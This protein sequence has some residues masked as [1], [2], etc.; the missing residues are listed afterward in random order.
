MKVE[1]VIFVA[2]SICF[3]SHAEAQVSQ[4]NVSIPVLAVRAD[5]AKGTMGV[6]R[7][8]YE[9][10]DSDRPL[11]ISVSD[12][13]P[14]GTG[15]S[16]R[17]A[18]WLAA[19]TA[20]VARNDPLTGVHLDFDLSGG[21]DGPSAGG[22]LCLAILSALDGRAIPNDFAMTGTIMA[23]GTIGAVGGIAEKLRA[24][25]RCGIKRVCIPTFARMDENFRDLLDLGKELKLEM[26]QVGTIAEAY[27]VLHRLP[28]RQVVRLN[29]AEV[30]RLSPNVENCLK[31]QF[32]NFARACPWDEAMQ[33]SQM[34]KSVEEFRAGLFGVAIMNL[35]SGLE[36]CV[37]AASK[38]ET[39][40]VERYPALEH[41]LPTN[42]VSVVGKLLG[43]TPT[44]ERFAEELMAFHRDLKA[45]EADS[46]DELEVSDPVGRED[47]PKGGDGDD[48][49]DDSV[50][51]PCG[52]QFIVLANENFLKQNLIADQCKSITKEIDSGDDWSALDAVQLNTVR[53]LLVSKLNGLSCRSTFED[54]GENCERFKAFFSQLMESAPYVRPNSSTPQVENTF[55][56]TMKSMDAVLNED[57]TT[58]RD[59]RVLIQLYRSVLALAEM[60]H[61]E[62]GGDDVNNLKAI[63]S[64]AQAISLACSLSLLR[65]TFGNSA[66]FSSIVSTARESALANIA[67]C[68]RR[69]IP[70]VMPVMS[71]QGAESR[72]DACATGDDA[73]LNRLDVICGY[74]EASIGAKALVLCF[75]G[76]KPELNAKGYCSKA[77]TSEEFDSGLSCVT[78]RYLGVEGEPI[79]R[80]GFSGWRL[81]QKDGAEY[82]SWLDLDGRDVRYKTTNECWMSTYDASGRLVRKDYCNDAWVP[83]PRADG[84]LFE[85]KGYD[86]DGNE[87]SWEFFGVAGK[88]V[89]GPGGVSVVRSQFNKRGQEVRRRFYDV[90]EKPVLHADGNAGYDIVYDKRGN[91]RIVTFVNCTGKPAMTVCGYAR[92]E[93]KYNAQG[94]EI[95][96]TWQDEHG[97]PVCVDGVAKV[98]SE[99]DEMGHLT[100]SACFGAD[101]NLKAGP[102][103]YAIAKWT[104]GKSGEAIEC[105]C[106]GANGEPTLHKDGYSSWK[107]VFDA[108]GRDVGC[109][110]YDAKGNE[111]DR[112]ERADAQND[113][114]SAK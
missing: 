37:F 24:A 31:N 90:N 74:L 8:R 6:I 98:V 14:L 88:R 46:D 97:K 54:G 36:D 91:E 52:A 25:S 44:K 75:A 59:D 23:D 107:T 60:F 57:S 17:A 79:L 33:N 5:N 27:Q 67:E 102:A 113:R 58:G 55:Y 84:V 56:R 30:C 93:C 92:R 19:V 47:G 39:P 78:V 9:R 110:Y 15:D 106:Y 82:T 109:K 80:G 70:C 108:A 41:E 65:E 26:H 100:T 21:T 53:E 61:S 114:C 89:N 63:F 28:A 11:K 34:N 85:T 94:L 73:E 22:V 71:F 103:N 66:F 86:A 1:A 3:F 76:Q 96:R 77:V 72:R 48:W 49:F 68:K 64:E 111:I 83:T 105:H 81:S 13:L 95:E 51:N 50:M 101:N 99:Y 2:I 16:F 35:M 42:K 40:P 62:R 12:D 32:A 10:E 29:P 43:K 45:I 104:Y 38:V 69:G 112:G 18:I 7:M 87:T 20:G 4:K